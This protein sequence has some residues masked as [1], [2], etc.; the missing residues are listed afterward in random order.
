MGITW[1][2]RL[3]WVGCSSTSPTLILLSSFLSCNVCRLFLSPFTGCQW[4]SR[5]WFRYQGLSAGLCTHG[6]SQWSSGSSRT[7][8]RLGFLYF[9]MLTW[10][11]LEW[12]NYAIC[13]GKGGRIIQKWFMLFYT[14]LIQVMQIF[15]ASSCLSSVSLWPFSL[16]S[17]RKRLSDLWFSCIKMLTT[18]LLCVAGGQKRGQGFTVFFSPIYPS[19][20]ES[21]CTSSMVRTFWTNRTPTSLASFSW[22]PAPPHSY[23]S[24]KKIDHHE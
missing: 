19:R 24:S 13:M 8:G 18:T 10:H 1:R 5:V 3:T 2:E 14:G 23:H 4:S 21:I 7:S 22:G 12:A 20:S 15:K 11:Y 16:F 6:W 9:L 17:I